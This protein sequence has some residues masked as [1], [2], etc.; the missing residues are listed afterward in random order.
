MADRCGGFQV[1]G[2]RRYEGPDPSQEPGIDPKAAEGILQIRLA[3]LG[4]G[5]GERIGIR[6]IPQLTV[7]RRPHDLRAESLRG[8]RTVQPR[9]PSA[10]GLHDLRGRLRCLPELRGWCVRP[11]GRR[12]R[13]IQ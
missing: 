8:D 5:V 9:R 7:R 6:L 11:G 4:H 3:V 2:R 1:V 10:R 12:G 13:L